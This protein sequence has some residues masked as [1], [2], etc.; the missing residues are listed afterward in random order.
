MQGGFK[1]IIIFY[2][3]FFASTI[4]QTSSSDHLYVSFYYLTW[5]TL[6][7]FF[8]REIPYGIHV[9]LYMHNIHV[10]IGWV[11][12]WMT[13]IYQYT[14]ITTPSINLLQK[15]QPVPSIYILPT[16]FTFYCVASQSA[17]NFQYM[18]YLCLHVL[19]KQNH[20]AVLR[21]WRY[22]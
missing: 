22:Y 11:T 8:W 2:F 20:P 1:L 13:L 17:C 6:E 9:Q 5:L 12:D 14:R 3:F 4:L 7:I 16:E 15:Q 10:Y 21:V 19:L 18:K